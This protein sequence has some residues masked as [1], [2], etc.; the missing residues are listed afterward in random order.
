MTY[1]T[2]SRRDL[3][4]SLNKL[5][6]TAADATETRWTLSVLARVVRELETAAGAN[7]ELGDTEQ[8]PLVVLQRRLGRV[9]R[10]LLA[11]STTQT[12][13]AVQAQT[14]ALAD[15]PLPWDQAM[16]GPAG[17]RTETTF[18]TAMSTCAP[19]PT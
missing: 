14:N 16:T 12:P 3:S 9:H 13:A 19:N 5:A 11:G 8:E 2:P 7:A 4:V 15:H 17:E 18:A 10:L 1:A 6:Q